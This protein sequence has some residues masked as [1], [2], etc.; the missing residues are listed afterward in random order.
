MFTIGKSAQPL[1]IVAAAA[2]VGLGLHLIEPASSSAQAADPTPASQPQKPIWAASATGRV[3]PKSGQILIGTQTP[4]RVADVAVHV[5]DQ[6]KAGDLLVRLDEDDLITRLNAAM[7]EVQ[8]RERE[9]E[10]EPAK[11]LQLEHRQADD[12]VSAAE[13]ALFRARL[14]FDDISFR[15]RTGT[16]RAVDVEAARTAIAKAKDQLV[17]ARAVLGSVLVREGLPLATRLESSLASARADLSLAEAAVERARIRAPIDGTVLSVLAKFGELVAPSAEGAVAVIGDM[18]GLRVKA[19]VEERDVTKVKVGQRV[20]IKGDAFPDR[21]FEGTVSEISPSMA[22][23][24]I[25]TRGVRKPNDVDVIEVTVTVDGEP[26]LIPGMRV[27]VFFKAEKAEAST[28]A[29]TT[30]AAEQTTE[31]AN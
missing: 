15:Q 13:R 25:A 18:S 17:S 10:E 2:I 20:V 11:G 5:N 21:T 22:T 31:H 28:H 19:E 30:A 26:V 1:A 12:A 23:P 24:R 14:T 27:D 6:V 4:G 9:R 3:E 7:A 8:V 16:G 29:R